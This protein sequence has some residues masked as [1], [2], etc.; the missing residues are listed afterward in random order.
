[1]SVLARLGTPTNRQWPRVKMAAKICSMTASWPTITF[2]SS[3]CMICRCCR[4]SC[5]TSP[6]LRVL[7]DNGVWRLGV[8]RSVDGD[9]GPTASRILYVGG[10]GRQLERTVHC[11]SRASSVDYQCT[12][13]LERWMRRSVARILACQSCAILLVVTALPVRLVAAPAGIDAAQVL[14]AIDRGVAFMK[15]DFDR[16]DRWDEMTGY[17]G[18]IAALCT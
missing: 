11:R 4:N 15:R 14:D 5:S 18:G 6:R 2:C 17:P 16:R 3:R 13:F 1:M 10:I 12:L 9:G 7:V 8:M